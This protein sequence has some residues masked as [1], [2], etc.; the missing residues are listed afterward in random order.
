MR[1]KSI[2]APKYYRVYTLLFVIA[3]VCIYGQ[4]LYYGKT[5]IEYHDALHQYYAAFEYFSDYMQEIVRTLFSTGHL[6]IPLWDFSIG[7]GGDVLTAMNYYVIGDPLNLIA[8]FFKNDQLEVVFQLLIL[9]RLYLGGLAFSLFCRKVGFRGWGT[10]AGAM[11]YSFCVFALYTSC[12]Y[13]AFP[14]VLIYLPLLFL[15]IEKVFRR[16]SRFPLLFVVALCLISN[17][18]FSYMLAALAVVYALIRYFAINRY[19]IRRGGR[20]G[21]AVVVKDFFCQV[22]RMIL[23]VLGGALLSCAVLFPV[24]YAFLNQGRGAGQVMESFLFYRFA[25]YV[26]LLGSVFSPK[27]ST[28]F[29]IM[30]YCPLVFCAI[31]LLFQ[32][33][34]G[35]KRIKAALRISFVVSAVFLLIP[36]FGY[37]LNGFAYLNNR[38]LFGLAFLS[39]FTVVVFFDDMLALQRRE[40]MVLTVGGAAYLVLYLLLYQLHTVAISVGLVW[41]LVFVL[42]PYFSD[43]AGLSRFKRQ[44]VLLAACV[45]CVIHFGFFFFS[46]LNTDIMQTK[47]D[48]GEIQELAENRSAGAT[49]CIEDKSF[50]RVDVMDPETLNEGLLLHYSPVSFYYSLFDG[51]ITAFNKELDNAD[52]TVPNMSHGNAGRTYLNLLTDVKYA[53]AKRKKDLPYGYKMIDT[54]EYEDGSKRVVGKNTLK[55]PFGYTAASCMTRESYEKLTPLKKEQAMLQSAVVEEKPDSM[56]EAVPVYTDRNIPYTVKGMDGMKMEKNKIQTEKNHAVLTLEADVPENTELFVSCRGIRFTASDPKAHPEYYGGGEELTSR[57]HQTMWNHQFKNWKEPVQ[58]VISASANGRTEEVT[59]QQ[60]GF[61]YYWQQDR[62]LLSLGTKQAGKK[63]QIEIRFSG[64]GEYRFSDL[65]LL[66]EDMT[67]LPGQISALKEEKMENIKFASNWVEGTIDTSGNRML[68][69]SVPYSKGWCVMVD[70]KEQ[71]LTCVNTMWSGV[72]LEH[73][74]RHKI[75]LQYRTPFLKIGVLLSGGTLFLILLLWVFLRMRRKKQ[76]S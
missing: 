46:P 63:Q 56:P 14:N 47:L 20:C 72:Y 67:V 28:N 30:G 45:I 24:L 41:L 21:T 71:E 42:L 4:F 44:T 40:K 74:G 57:F 61:K 6:E 62:F 66:T 37:A 36:F 11:I 23:P 16:E 54:K 64:I 55:P 58:I 43:A 31:L 8:V 49:D 60:E 10:A 48:A 1:E 34:H 38:W 76:I 65:E 2:A 35:K 19:V 68:M 29:S 5:I 33:A 32:K 9:F 73:A 39:A 25:D 17:F 27:I 53:V 69:L 51:K 7:M 52:M 26:E 15:G 50:Y 70:G 75:E 22:G 13:A 59:L 3:A 12:M 18:Y